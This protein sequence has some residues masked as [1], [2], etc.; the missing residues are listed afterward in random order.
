M[1]GGSLQLAK[2]TSL[3][4]ESSQSNLSRGLGR[5]STGAKLANAAEDAG[6]L[7]VS[8]KIGAKL[9]Q[10]F[11]VR[12]NVQNARSFLEAQDSSFAS[13]GKILDRMAELRTKHDDLAANQGDRK[14]YNKEFKEMQSEMLSLR[15]HKFNGVSIFSS[16]PKD[17][18][19][20]FIPTSDDAQVAINRTGFFDNL[21]I[22]SSIPGSTPLTTVVGD[23]GSMANATVNAA[24]VGTTTGFQL[25]PAAGAM[26]DIAVTANAAGTTTG[27]KLT[28]A[29]GAMGDIAVTANAA[30]TTTGFKLTPAAGA[31]GDIAVTANAAGTT[32]GFKLTPAAGAMGDIAVTANAAGTTAGFKLTPANGAMGDIAVTANAA[33]TTSGFKLTPAAGGMGD[34]AVTANAAGTTTG[35]KLTPAAGAMGNIAVTANAAGTTSGFK[36]TPAAGAMGNIAVNA[37]AAGT[38]TGFQVTPTS[39]SMTNIAVTAAATGTTPAT[40]NL[41]PV[42]GSMP[43]LS[44]TA[45][46]AGTVT[47]FQL[48]PAAGSMGASALTITA[49][50]AVTTPKVEAVQGTGSVNVTGTGGSTVP[51]AWGT[52]VPGTGVVTEKAAAD[53]A[54]NLYFSAVDATNGQVQIHKVQP[55]GTIPPAFNTTS[56]SIAGATDVTAPVV[57]GN[58]VYVGATG[59]WGA[60]GF[61]DNFRIY[62]FDSTSGAQI[63]APL[64]PDGGGLGTLQ[65]FSE[66]N[67]TLF[68]IY[69]KLQGF[70][71][72]PK[73]AAI[74]PATNTLDTAIFPGQTTAGIYESPNGTEYK[75]DM[76]VAVDS[77]GNV[78]TARQSGGNTELVQK[79]LT[80]AENSVTIFGETTEDTHPVVSGNVVVVGTDGGASGLAGKVYGFN[81][82]TTAAAWGSP[83]D[84]GLNPLNPGAAHNPRGIA[85]APDGSVYVGT[86]QGAL[87]RIDATTGTGTVFDAGIGG[88]SNVVGTPD[89]DAAGNVYFTTGKG[90]TF[91]LPP[92]SLTGATATWE[93][94]KTGG[95]FFANDA[96]APIVVGTS[97]YLVTDSPSEFTKLTNPGGGVTFPSATV[98]FGSNYAVADGKPT[99][100]VTQPDG[101][102]TQTLAAADVTN[103]GD[104]T[105][106]VSMANVTKA[107]GGTYALAA[108][109]GAIRLDT[110]HVNTTLNDHGSGY[111]NGETP[112]LVSITDSGGTAVTGLTASAAAQVDQKIDVSVSGTPSATGTL[113]LTFDGP[114]QTPANLTNVGSGYDISETAPL[115]DITNGT[116]DKGTLDGIATINAN[117]TLNITFTGNAKSKGTLSVKAKDGTFFKIPASND[118]GSGYVNLETPAVKVTRSGTAVAGVAGSGTAGADGKVDL[119]FTGNA[120][121]A[122]PVDVAVAPGNITFPTTS[123]TVQGSG[124]DVSE[125][126]A[127]APVITLTPP[128]G[129]GG[130]QTANATVAADGT[131]S[132]TLPTPTEPGV[133]TISAAGGTYF[134][135]PATADQGS[136]YAVGVTP[137]VTVARGGVAVPGVTGSGTADAGGLVDLTFTG[138][139]GSAATVNVTVADGA[140][141]FPTSTYTG[142]SGGYHTSETPVITITPPS[143]AAGAKTVN[144]V[145]AA[146][147]TLSFT[148]PAPTEAGPH[149][150][151]AANGTYFQ[152]ADAIDQGS[153]Y[154][155]ASTPAVTL[156]K[157]GAAVVGLSAV[158]TA[159]T[160]GKVDVVFTGNAGS[161]TPVD[162]AVANGPMSFATTAYTGQGS[163][164]NVSETGVG[165]PQ[166]TVTGPTGAGGAQTVNATVAANGTLSFTLP[167]PN[168]TGAHTI[169][170]AAGSYFEVPDSNNQGGGYATGATPTV[171]IT[172]AGV[173]VAGVSG[174]ATAGTD[175]KVDITFTGNAAN[176]TDVDI[177]VASGPMTFATTNY[178]AIA[179]GYHT[180]ENPVIT[181]TGSAGAGGA[182]TVNATVAGDGTLSF[183]LPTPN[184]TG[185]HTIT[186]AAGTYFEVADSDDHGSGYAPGGTPTVSITR[187]GVAVAGVSGTATAGADGKV[188]ITFTGNAAN[189]T[190]VDI[191]V[192][193]GPMTF[194]TTAYTGQ[195]SGYNVSETGVGAPQ[196]TVTG[197]AGAGGAQT[198]NATVAANG[199]LSFTLPTPNETGAHTI[200][201]AAG[202][203]DEI[204][205]SNDHGSGYA[206]GDTPT[207][208][209]TRGGVAVAGVSGTAT[210]G[211]DGKVDITFTG[212]AAGLTDVDIAVASGPMTFATTNYTA[213]AGG[214]D[215]S[216]NPVIT[217]TGPA[218]AGGAQT[219]NATVAGDGTLSFVL[220]TPNETGAH[221]ITG[222]AG[223]HFEIPDSNDHGSGYATGDTPTVTIT[224]AGVAV[225]GVSGTASAGTD[226]KVDITFTGDAANLT[227]VDIAVANGPMTFATTNYTA[228]AGGYH[229]SE[230]PV[231]TVTG[232]AGAGGAQTVNATVAGDG[233]LSF[234]LPTPN[235]TG[236]HTITGAAGSFFEIPDSNNQGG[237]YATGDTPTVSI[238]RGGVAVAGVSGTATAG[239]DGKV[240]ITFTGDAANLTDVDIAVANGPM[241]FATTNYTGI[242]GGYHTSENPVITVTGPAGAGGAQTVN[243]TV[244]GDGTLSF[245]L[246]TP[247]E[248]GAHTITGAAGSYDEIPDSNDHGSGYAPGDTP[249]VSITR[250]GVAVAGVSGVA[251]AG[252]DGKVDITFTGD[253]AGLTDVDIAVANGPM[254]F[255]TT[256][257]TGIAGGYHTSENPVITV[258]G[259]AGAGGAQTVNATVAGDG[260]LSFV[261]PTPNETGA[262][263]ITGAAGSYDEIPDSNDHGSGYAPGDTPTVAITRAGVAV[264]GVSGTATAGADGKVDITFT[265]DAAGLTDVDIAV[266]NGPMTF[267]TTNYTGIAGGYHTSENP[268][269][270]VT[271]P[272][273]AGGAQTVNA[274]VAGDGTL[275]FVL[276]TPNETGAHTITGAAGSYAEVPDSNDH[277][278]GYAT[279]DTPTVTITR[280]GVAV[281][282]VSGTATAGADGKVDITFTGDA[283]NLTNVDVSVASGGLALAQSSFSGVGSGYDPSET[284]LITI[285]PPSGAGGAQTVNA[286]VAA[287]GTLSFTL[288]NPTE[289]GF[290][291]IS[292][293]GGNMVSLPT[294]LNIGSGYSPT[295]PPPVV[296]VTDPGGV[297]IAGATSSINTNGTI[298]VNL[299]AITPIAGG[300]PG[301]YTVS[302]APGISAG[303]QNG[304]DD[305]D[306]DL[307]D[308]SH[309]DFDTFIQTL[310]NVR[311][312]NGATM[313]SLSF[314]E[315]RLESNIQNLEKAGGRIVDADMAEEM[316]EV[317]KNQ[318]L[319]KT[320]T[321]SLTKHNR[322]SVSVDKT[323]MGLSGGM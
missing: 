255:A 27:F 166:I 3:F 12:E 252:A 320:A 33:G 219:V 116:G 296:T 307:W 306:K 134:K 42:A 208:S 20:F 282:G 146:D 158:G 195:G 186:G 136:G 151:S 192:A 274:T 167:T 69:N 57:V 50:A 152:I 46:A 263:T 98:S 140:L 178:T 182:Q 137:A 279:G 66:H 35:F 43:N 53:A 305:W 37:T 317:A 54:G 250:G 164:Y 256:N 323:L 13:L 8:M 290:H 297:P 229:T 18:L 266:A 112:A 52:A 149:A 185:A 300:T 103:N 78:W 265:G 117:G 270:T 193:N 217:V 288:P 77:G 86:S 224:R 123:F 309:E 94:T 298:S 284:P 139:A 254:T 294:G 73:I 251:T 257:Y 243:A 312:V 56:A 79:G 189:L 141:A 16:D 156:T 119:T 101:V 289:S 319:L 191:T 248:T 281:A 262:H 157:S 170:G 225:A 280:G 235:E 49:A 301:N 212:D 115:V 41:T 286:T 5:L 202:S 1:L 61:F 62:R 84:L 51:K 2:S 238:T 109:N 292:A 271:G 165:A 150:I 128:S 275:S 291:V 95:G 314:S 210:A 299:S 60:F 273:G 65:S 199:T 15:G 206:P 132:F 63:G 233:T 83:Y 121:S 216:E 92:G 72:R 277:G 311:A 126:G 111:Y 258:T 308:F 68:A 91:K 113:T 31:M 34:I 211:A 303:I 97:A 168:E 29:A 25:T 114:L 231:I 162:V 21:T 76:E 239:T 278:S 100:T 147:G 55:D 285:T 267:A 144:A 183:V 14:L 201:G 26:G 236:A 163:G 58:E 125:T 322:L 226:G 259:P 138:N 135:I 87:H 207:V 295:E 96:T 129:A 232:P 215:T 221:T 181:V 161:A 293:A 269:I 105:L 264:A 59:P 7:G 22:G 85:V 313:N 122:T 70:Q 247:N 133:H 234:V 143:G 249:T 169:T 196:I 184:E 110:S 242:A 124:Y 316:L 283:A 64:T 244:A 190:D 107:G 38:T 174:T 260:T 48:T 154:A 272:A 287:D 155:N 240:D 148:L 44:A 23:V 9:K 40:I 104:G 173:A 88:T 10:A 171:T 220:P 102:T 6:N 17:P 227:D 4:M 142:Q 237:G 213:I 205:D 127:G 218:G 159:G 318:I 160:D 67:G 246:P 177:A 214:Y 223:S 74:D 179:G 120:G 198:V 310:S 28:P 71:S 75:S 302:V 304:L 315:S 222:A 80:G 153:G 36:L 253:A 276:P 131:L 188:D 261:L 321:D 81:T 39:G 93:H 106:T 108:S 268:V 194:A 176:L 228:I 197:P 230:N 175:G 180:S 99:V 187:G 19:S 82:T 130:A 203:Y 241:T 200:T 89:F 90:K 118:Q 172:R 45:T 47:N 24:N 209:I 32:T 11:K 30:G 245:V 145:V 204:P